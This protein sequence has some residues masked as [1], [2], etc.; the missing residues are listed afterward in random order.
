MGDADVRILNADEMQTVD[1]TAIE[2][3]GIPGLVLMENAALGVVDAI[4]ERYA[5]ATSAVV[6][7]GPG[8]NGGD[9]LAIARHLTLRGYGVTVLLVGWSRNRSEDATLQH[10]LCLRQGVPLVELETVDDLRSLGPV[11]LQADLWID[12]LFG[13]GLKRPLEGLFATVVGWLAVRDRPVIAVDLPS[14]LDA[15]SGEVQGPAASAELTVTFAAPKRA[16]I[17]SPARDRCGQIVVTDLGTPAEI[18]EEAPGFLHLLVE[19]ELSAY[20]LD[21]APGSHKGDFGHCLVVAGSPGKSGAASLAGQA[22][23]RAGAGL[24][25]IAV[26]GPLLE[27]VDTVSLESMSLAL[28]ADGSG[29]LTVDAADE[30]LGALDRK[31]ALALGPGL[32]TR[33]TTTTA[34]RRIVEHCP[35]PLVLDADGLN[36]LAGSAAMLR[37]RA[38]PTVLTPHPGE[39][40][41]LF[42]G[43]SLEIQASRVEFARRTA[44]EHRVIL[45]LK[46]YQ[47]LVATPGGEVYVNLTGNPGMATGGTGDVLTG[48]LGALL[49]Q[50]YDAEVAA[51][52]G[53]FL[54]GLAG[55]L[56]AEE[57]GLEGL[58]ATD[59]LDALPSAFRRLRGA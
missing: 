51:C 45:I 11:D 14:G 34:V 41:R 5:H 38:A 58:A 36:A 40:A 46:G 2:D 10:R 44:V 55:D 48:T 59:L 28:S 6:F 12:A 26:P 39:A 42:G 50:G 18:V 27:A 8:N 13:T 24:V 25:T 54:H 32:G 22:A 57:H 1:R 20:L 21:P 29:C 23:V 17:F 4:S 35:V 31:Q 56:A 30:V 49:A 37:D 19:D 16:H 7:C 52:L 15:S 33:G 47:T 43:T 9:G 3:W 53:V